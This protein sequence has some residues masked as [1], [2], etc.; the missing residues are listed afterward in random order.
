MPRFYFDV[1]DGRGFH[2]D[3]VGDECVDF[4][5]AR[6]HA[7][8]LLPDIARSELPDGEMH[9]ITCDVRDEAGRVVYRD[10]LTYEGTRDPQEGCREAG[11]KADG[12]ARVFHPRPWRPG[13]RLAASIPLR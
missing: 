8:S 7:Q 9:S 10:K 3:D 5:E 1:R 13:G 4:D 12:P 6:D 2:L 11:S